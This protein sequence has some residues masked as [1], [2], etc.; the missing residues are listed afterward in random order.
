M[1]LYNIFMNAAGALKGFF[2]LVKG[3][4]KQIKNRSLFAISFWRDKLPTR[5]E[6]LLSQAKCLLVK[7]T[8]RERRI[9]VF[10]QSQHKLV[11]II[12]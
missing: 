3:E 5:E 9:D 8:F 12:K 6:F 1:I 7:M 10:R 2:I 4:F 11:P